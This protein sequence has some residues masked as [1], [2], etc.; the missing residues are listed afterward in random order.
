MQELSGLS[1]ALDAAVYDPAVSSVRL[2]EE[3]LLIERRL[4]H[5]MADAACGRTPPNGSVR[6]KR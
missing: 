1:D 3:C 6:M 2:Q 4:A 5:L